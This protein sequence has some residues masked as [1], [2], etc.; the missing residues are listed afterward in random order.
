MHTLDVVQSAQR[1]DGRAAGLS[2]GSAP[3]TY[4]MDLVAAKHRA[5]RYD[6]RNPPGAVASTKTDATEILNQFKEPEP[7]V[8]SAW[9][10]FIEPS[11]LR[12][13]AVAGHEDV[14]ASGKDRPASAA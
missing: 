7:A 6:K 11:R 9:L 3:S 10:S 1:P 8:D 14:A 5:R 2:R 13:G 12:E 4:S